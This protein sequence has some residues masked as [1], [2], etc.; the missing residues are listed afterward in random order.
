MTTAQEPPS[1]VELL[2]EIAEW[3]D[4]QEMDAMPATVRRAIVALKEPWPDI[5]EVDRLRADRDRLR[6]HSM[7]LNR[8]SWE[9]HQALG[10]IPE[11][12]TSHHGP[13]ITDELPRICELIR[14]GLE[15]EEREV[16]TPW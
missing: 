7:M 3:M 13:L 15:A 8:V 5:V 12:A 10:V 6:E 11:G 4:E 2:E 1:L 16:H 14:K 9:I